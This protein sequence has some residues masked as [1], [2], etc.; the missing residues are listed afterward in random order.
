MHWACG[1]S[2]DPTPR[3]PYAATSDAREQFANQHLQHDQFL[4]REEEAEAAWRLKHGKSRRFKIEKRSARICNIQRL[5]KITAPIILRRRKDDCGLPIVEKIVKPLW[6]RPGTM[7]QRVYAFHLAHPPL[8]ARGTPHKAVD[9][10]VQIG[11]QLGTLRLAAL[12]PQ[13]QSLADTVIHNSRF[14]GTVGPKKSFTDLN[15]KSAG[16]LGLLADLVGEGEQVIVGSPF[17]EFNVALHRRLQQAGVS[18]VL[19]NGSVSPTARGQYAARFKRQEFSVAVAGLKAMG[20]G[21][22]FECARHLILP[23][24][25]FA[26]DENEQFIHRVWRLNSRAAVSIWQFIMS[27]TIDEVLLQG[28]GDKLDS[29]QLAL[30]GQLVEATVET[31]DVAEVL[32]RATKNFDPTAPTHDE[33][34]MEAQWRDSLCSRLRAAEERFRMKHGRSAAT[35]EMHD[36]PS[37]LA[38]ALAALK[39]GKRAF[40]A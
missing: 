16:V 17:D 15:P 9:R 11:M 3:F 23:S 40:A 31:V 1:S 22:S 38:L 30:D 2:P 13:A 35:L 14:T 6:V 26:L 27:N 28:F 21:H 18:S 5:W 20:K 19:L 29:A 8:A 34:E 7:Q 32:A 37:P 10:R 24:M 39:K 33:H 4:T 36:E 12:C 25:S